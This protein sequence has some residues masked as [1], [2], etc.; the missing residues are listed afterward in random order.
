MSNK[1][2]KSSNE[3]GLVVCFNRKAMELCMQE[4]GYSLVLRR[5]CFHVGILFSEAGLDLR[6]ASI[7]KE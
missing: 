6:S 7:L 3:R 1:S 2:S 4:V 5:Y